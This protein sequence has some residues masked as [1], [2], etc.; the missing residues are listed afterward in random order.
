M[1]SEEKEILEET[2][3]LAKENNKMLKRVR[4][5]QKRQFL[6]LIVKSILII[7]IAFGLFLYLEPFLNRIMGFTTQFSGAEKGLDSNS[8]QQFLLH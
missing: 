8:L 1:E 6:W 4:G 3:E 5:V 7:G 2:L